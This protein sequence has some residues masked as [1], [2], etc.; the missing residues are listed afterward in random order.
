MRQ[1]SKRISRKCRMVSAIS[2]D[3]KY[4]TKKCSDSDVMTCLQKP[5]HEYRAKIFWNIF[6]GIEGVSNIIVGEQY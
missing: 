1:T 4:I 3:F 2:Q 6:S 5:S